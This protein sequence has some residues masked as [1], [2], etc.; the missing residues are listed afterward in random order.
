MHHPSSF[1]P[2]TLPLLKPLS[3]ANTNNEY[4]TGACVM[5]S[6][7]LVASLVSRSHGADR[8]AHPANIN[9]AAVIPGVT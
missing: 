4:I 7:R 3:D 8:C 2:L 5:V 1:S 6:L 9:T